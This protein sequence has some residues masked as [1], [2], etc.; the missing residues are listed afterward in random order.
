MIVACFFGVLDYGSYLEP[1]YLCIL[2]RNL[3]YDICIVHWTW[4][5]CHFAINTFLTYIQ[6]QALHILCV[7]VG[8][9][10]SNL[11]NIFFSLK[12]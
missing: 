12:I 11:S 1:H 7:I 6:E 4:S 3:I 8:I 10:V 5:S 9:M 2:F